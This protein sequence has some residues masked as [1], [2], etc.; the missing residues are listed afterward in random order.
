MTYSIFARAI[1]ARLIRFACFIFLAGLTMG[2]PAKAQNL[3]TCLQGYVWREARPSDVVCV[4]PQS[5][6]VV[7]AENTAA[8]SRTE[9]GPRDGVYWCLSGFEWR[10]AF[11]GDRACVPPHARDRVGWENAQANS[12]TIGG[13]TEWNVEGRH[14]L[15]IGLTFSRG[16]SQDRNFDSTCGRLIALPGPMA[17]RIGWGQAEIGWLGENCMSFVLEKAVQFDKTLIGHLA[18]KMIIDSVV[19]SYEENEAPFCPLV[20]GYNYRCWQNGDGNYPVKQDG[21]VIVRVPSA[22]W[23]RTGGAFPGRLP[24]FQDFVT[25]VR[26]G[27]S[28]NSAEQSSARPISA[29]SQRQ[30]EQGRK[31]P[32]CAGEK[33]TSP[34]RTAKPWTRLCVTLGRRAVRTAAR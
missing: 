2:S 12:R 7:A 29:K 9:S 21:C 17:G 10:E 14:V 32:R 26:A 27:S 23:E 28:A 8:P 31:I 15:E 3:A 5:R 25:P 18:G 22:D 4:T 30:P 6:S 16:A 24:V 11:A 1:F 34:R 19:L 20:V 33:D 13:G